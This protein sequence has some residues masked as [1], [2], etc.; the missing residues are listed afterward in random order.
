MRINREIT[1]K[2]RLLDKYGNIAHPGYSKKLNWIYDRNDIKAPK[3]R[4]K[5]WD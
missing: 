3:W 4:I 2:E 5:E 1:E